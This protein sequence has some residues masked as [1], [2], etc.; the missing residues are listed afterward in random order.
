MDKIRVGWV[1]DKI[2]IENLKKIKMEIK[3]FLNPSK[4]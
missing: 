2:V 3:E 1:C 4:R